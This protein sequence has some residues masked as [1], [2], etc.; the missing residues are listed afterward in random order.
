MAGHDDA[1]NS[2]HALLQGRWS[3][4]AYD[5]THE[6]NDEELEQ[7]FDA[8]RWA[9]SCFNAQPWRY[10]YARR[11]DGSN[12][13]KLLS[14]LVE[15]NRNWAKRASLVMIAVAEDNFAHNGKPNAWAKHDLGAASAHLS[16]QASALGL[17]AHSMG[18]FDAAGSR[19]KLGIPDGYTP[20]AAIAVGRPAPA[21][22][23]DDGLKEREQATRERKQMASIAFRG[24]F[25]S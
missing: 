21:D 5:E 19:D 20:V 7:L 8:A 1:P 22:I 23:L 12:F 9:A 3:P 6:L 4:R 10:V 16:L 15:G 18:G 14:C 11:Q 24:Q 2:I 25:A 17:Q 13:D